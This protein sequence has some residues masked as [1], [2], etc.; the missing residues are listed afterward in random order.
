MVNRDISQHPLSR[1]QNRKSKIKTTPLIHLAFYTKD[2]DGV[3]AEVEKRGWS[4]RGSR[5]ELQSRYIFVKDPNGYDIEI[6]QEK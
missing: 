6:L 2:L 5:P 3:I 1:L 4:Y